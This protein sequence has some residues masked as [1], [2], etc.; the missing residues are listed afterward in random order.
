MPTLEHDQIHPFYSG[1]FKKKRLTGWSLFFSSDKTK[2][3]AT[4]MKY[5]EAYRLSKAKVVFLQ[6]CSSRWIIC[7]RIGV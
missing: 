1:E 7:Q 6:I 5:K 4:T 3:E 2:T